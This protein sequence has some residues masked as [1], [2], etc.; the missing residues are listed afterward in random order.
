MG[1]SYGIDA[2]ADLN[3]GIKVV[4]GY[5]SMDTAGTF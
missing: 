2:V 3:N 4:E 5:V 1:T